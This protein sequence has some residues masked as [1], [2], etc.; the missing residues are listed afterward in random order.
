MIAAVIAA[1]IAVPPMDFRGKLQLWQP[2]RL[3]SSNI[4]SN[5]SNIRLLQI[6][7]QLGHHLHLHLQILQLDLHTIRIGGAPTAVSTTRRGTRYVG[8]MAQWVVKRRE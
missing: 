8:E 2:W 7:Q 5:I 6:M 4:S 1:S 3:C